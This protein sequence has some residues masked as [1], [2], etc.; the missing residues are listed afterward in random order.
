MPLV[1]HCFLLFRIILWVQLNISWRRITGS[2]Y[3]LVNLKKTFDLAKTETV[4]EALNKLSL[5]TKEDT[6]LR[7]HAEIACAWWSASS[8]AV[9]K[10]VFAI[11]NRYRR[12]SYEQF[13]TS[14]LTPTPTMSLCA[15]GWMFSYL[16]R[17]KHLRRAGLEPAP[18]TCPAEYY[19]YKKYFL[20]QPIY[21]MYRPWVLINMLFLIRPWIAE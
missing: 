1:F 21:T 2:C 5:Q 18:S 4:V 8:N 20:H 19:A 9:P 15:V 14:S 7:W 12:G 10:Y 6:M 13:S 3:A 11:Y 17:P 16:A